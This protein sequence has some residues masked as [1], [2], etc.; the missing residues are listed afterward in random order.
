MPKLPILPVSPLTDGSGNT[1]P[2][3]L[4]WFNAVYKNSLATPG[5]YNVLYYGAKGDGVTDDSRAINAAINAAVVNGVGVVYFPNPTGGGYAIGSPIILPSNVLLLGDNKKGLKLSRIKPM[6]AY[7]GHLIESTDWNATAAL[8]TRIQQSG[9]VGLFL[10]GSGTTLT[11]VDLYCQECFFSDNTYQNIFTYGIRI[12]GNNIDLGLNNNIFDNYF[13]KVGS[14]RFYGAVFEDYYTADN[15]FTNNYI[16][17]CDNAGIESRGSNCLITENHIFDCKYHILSRDTVERQ[18]TDNYLEFCTHSSIRVEN[19]SSSENQ[20]FMIV[21]NNIFRN[22][23][24][25]GTANGV[26]EL[27][28]TDCDYALI[29]GNALRRDAGTVYSTPYF[30][31]KSAAPT[32]VILDTVNFIYVAAAITTGL[33]N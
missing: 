18:I 12:A 7:T 10:D 33:I 15:K 23:N 14:N 8:A 13:T 30:V 3:W 16:E 5:S 2:V 11:A 9:I 20:L 28:G 19:G 24:T 26:I 27:D 22:I 17:G 4:N 6:P 32:N 21:A 1:I 31:W 25:G 29:Q